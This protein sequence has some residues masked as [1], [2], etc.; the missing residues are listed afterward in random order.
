MCQY[1][2][3]VYFRKQRNIEKRITIYGIITV[4]FIHLLRKRLKISI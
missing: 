1:S 3:L 2:R 4:F